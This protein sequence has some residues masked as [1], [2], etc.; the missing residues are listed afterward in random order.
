MGSEYLHL[1]LVRLGYTQH[2]MMPQN[3]LNSFTMSAIIVSQW[4]EPRGPW[5]WS[6]GQRS[7]FLL[8]RSEF[9]SL[10]L[11]Y[12]LYEKTK[13]NEKEAGVGPSLIKSLLIWPI[14]GLARYKKLLQGQTRPLP[15]TRMQVQLPE[16]QRRT[17]KQ[18]GWPTLEP[19]WRGACSLKR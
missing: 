14:D 9:K 2:C 13:I 10:W 12:F 18:Q 19:R 11:L 5:W 1:A 16:D 3:D 17:F 15:T 4:L 8:Q 7:C 6:S